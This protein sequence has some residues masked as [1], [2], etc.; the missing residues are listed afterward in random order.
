EPNAMTLATVDDRGRP[1]AR[2]GLLKDHDARGFTFYQ[3]YQTRKGGE[4]AARPYAA[5][6]FFWVELERQIRIEGAVEQVDGATA[7]AY[8]RK[9]PRASRLSAWASPQ[10]T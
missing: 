9:R 2:I 8:F 3:K 10:S 5:L 6:V 1:A 7:D 4:V